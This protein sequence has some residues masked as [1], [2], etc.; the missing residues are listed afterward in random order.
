MSNIIIPEE[1]RKEFRV[2]PDGKAFASIRGT[3]RIADVDHKTLVDSFKTAG[4]KNPSKLAQM[5]IDN[6]FDP[7]GFSETG[8][9]DLALRIVLKYYAFKANQTKEQAERFYDAMSGVGIRTWIQQQLGWRPQQ[10]ASDRDLPDNL[11]ALQLLLDNAAQM[12]RK[13]QELERRQQELETQQREQSLAV[14]EILEDKRI[15]TEQLKALPAPMVEAPDLSA[16]AKV[17]QLVRNYVGRTNVSHREA[18]KRLY[19]EFFYRCSYNAGERAKNRGV[20]KL[21]CIEQ[22]GLMEKLYA[23]GCKVFAI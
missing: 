6:G 14:T 17:N 23:V 12:H 5:L 9:P 16:R 10:P 11:K 2:E 15:A 20:K 3:A 8:V 22:D 21:D 19:K 7:G 4:G 13:Q 1:I 18:W